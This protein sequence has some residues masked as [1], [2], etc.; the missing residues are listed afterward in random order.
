MLAT[1]SDAAGAPDLREETLQVPERRQLFA[2]RRR[3][4]VELRNA[5]RAA[6]FSLELI[7]SR[8]WCFAGRSRNP[9]GSLLRQAPGN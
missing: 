7:A 9:T 5:R 4:A 6:K 2:E 1:V 3:S 8:R